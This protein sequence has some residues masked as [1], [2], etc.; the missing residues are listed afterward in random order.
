MADISGR[1][2]ETI[3]RPQDVGAIGA[4]M[5]AAVGLGVL[6]DFREIKSYVPLEKTYK[7]RQEYQA[8]YNQKYDVFKQL[9]LKNKSLFH[10]L[11]RK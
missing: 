9:Y 11:N 3:K 2:I 4:A 7:P 5:I 1:T 10:K 8:V 6:K